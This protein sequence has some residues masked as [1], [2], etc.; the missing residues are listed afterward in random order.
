MAIQPNIERVLPDH[1]SSSFYY[2]HTISR[3]EKRVFQPSGGVVVSKN[4]LID[5]TTPH[6]GWIALFS[7]RDIIE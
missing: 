5:T 2:V 4:R 6:V 3:R 7:L 1:G